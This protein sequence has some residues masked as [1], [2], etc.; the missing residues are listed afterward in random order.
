[1]SGKRQFGTVRK[2]P[3]GRWQARYRDGSGQ[4]IAAPSTFAT[5]TDA[6][7]FLAVV[8]ADMARGL[9]IDPRAGRVTLT[10]WSETWLTRPGKRAASTTRDRQGIAAFLSVIGSVYLSGLT[11]GLIQGTVDA[12]SKV[13]APAT[14]ARDFSALRAALN[15]AVDAEL[16]PRS[17]AR[18]IALPRAAP[19]EEFG[20]TPSELSDL[21]TELP[22]HYR[23]I[24]LVAAVLGLRWGEAIGLR[25]R[26]VDF[27]RRTV[28]VAQVVEELAGHMRMVP[29]AKTR[30][31]LR[32]LSAPFFLMDELASHLANHRSGVVGSNIDPDSLIF[33]GPR[34]GVLRRRFGERIL[35]PAAVRAGLPPS[36]T[37]HGLRHSAVTAM[38]DAGVPYNVTQARAGHAT[39]RMTME[40]YSHRTSEA[41]RAAAEALQQHFEEAFSFESGTGV[42]RSDSGAP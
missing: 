16:I 27:M 31:S 1:M 13:A 3:S 18:K 32:T 2:L 37:F 34:G 11:P 5:K 23:V 10:E 24:V 17:P 21:V 40:L 33:L 9:Y 35:R 25:V 20:L 29:E 22:G 39:A 8:E 7:R 26:D 19:S 6:T 41:D 30:S 15:A 36:L 28:T 4:I 42:A 14:V 12:R 38:A